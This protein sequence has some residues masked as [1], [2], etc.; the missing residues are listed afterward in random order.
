MKDGVCV[1]PQCR[2][3]L[4]GIK[5]GLCDECKAERRRIAKLHEGEEARQPRP[6]I[7][8]RVEMY[9]EWVANGGSLEELWAMC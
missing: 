3:P 8:A 7:K 4:V 2:T 1:T 5:A 9:R 6:H